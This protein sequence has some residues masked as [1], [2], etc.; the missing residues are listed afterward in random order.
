[1]GEF[2]NSLQSPLPPCKVDLDL[3]DFTYYY[4]DFNYI[5]VKTIDYLVSI[6]VLQSNQQGSHYKVIIT[7]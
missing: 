2:Q 1:M 7:F 3:P 5:S 6:G 4:Q